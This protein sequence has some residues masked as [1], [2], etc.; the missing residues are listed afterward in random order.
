LF[1]AKRRRFSLYG[2]RIP[3]GIANTATAPRSLVNLFSLPTSVPFVFLFLLLSFRTFVR[4]PD[5]DADAGGDGRGP[6]VA[7]RL[8]QSQPGQPADGRTGNGLYGDCYAIASDEDDDD[9]LLIFV[10]NDCCLSP[11]EPVEAIDGHNK[12]INK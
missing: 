3:H 1:A 7:A 9:G 12:Q 2:T 6:V 8:E 10:G 11:T 4:R 5:R